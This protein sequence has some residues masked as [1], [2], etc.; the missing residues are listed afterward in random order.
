MR[1]EPAEPSAGSRSAGPV[2]GSRQSVC[3]HVNVAPLIPAAGTEKVPV[4]V[5]PD[6]VPMLVEGFPET[7]TLLATK[8]PVAEIDP[9]HVIAREPESTLPLHVENAPVGV[10]R[11]ATKTSSEPLDAAQW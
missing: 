7:S 3:S 11:T 8:S 10:G 2:D 4:T 9:V 1:C 6:T 5:D